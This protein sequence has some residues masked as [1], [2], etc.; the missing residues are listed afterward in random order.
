MTVKALGPLIG[1]PQTLRFLRI[2]GSF[3]AELSD[4]PLDNV[5]RFKYLTHAS[6]AV[7]WIWCS[8]GLGVQIEE[9]P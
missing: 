5:E 9:R 6:A 2:F 1:T 8:E 4:F 3:R 7:D